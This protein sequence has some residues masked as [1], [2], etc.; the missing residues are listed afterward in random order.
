MSGKTKTKSPGSG[1]YRPIPLPN[2]GDI[3]G[4]AELLAIEAML[5]PTGKRNPL[6]TFRCACGAEFAQRYWNIRTKERRGEIVRCRPCSYISSQTVRKKNARNQHS[7][8]VKALAELTED[9]QQKVNRIV[10]RHFHAIERYRTGIEGK[11]KVYLHRILQEA[12]EL[13]LMERRTLEP[14]LPRW[15]A[16]NIN[17][18]LWERNYVQYQSPTG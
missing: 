2:P 16:Q 10:W 5:D 15:T 1:R 13:V 8:G 7:G 3:I 17:E 4:T 12:A 6:L 11:P 9:E 14:S 18:G